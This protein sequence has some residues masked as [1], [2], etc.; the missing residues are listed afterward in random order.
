MTGSTGVTCSVYLD[1]QR[2]ADGSPG[3]N[4]L[5]PTALSGL[6]VVWGR[7]TTVDQPEPNTCT[8][9]VLDDAGG[10]SFLEQLRTGRRIDVY[11]GGTFYPEDPTAPM[12][13]DP[14]FEAAP[15]GSVPPSVRS[16]ARVVVVDTRATS[17]GPFTV[18]GTNEFINPAAVS[19]TNFGSTGG[20]MNTLSLVTDF[21]DPAGEVSTAVRSTTIGT[22]NQRLLDFILG[23]AGYTPNTQYRVRMLIDST[24][25]VSLLVHARANVATTGSS[26]VATINL[27]VGRNV[28]DFVATTASSAPTATA[29]FTLI[30]NV[31]AG[32]EL[33]FA[34]ILF[35]KTPI[36]DAIDWISGD[37]QDKPN[38]QYD[39]LGPANASKST[40]STRE[41]GH[42]AQIVPT[43]PAGSGVVSFAPAPLSNAP[44]AWDALT[45]TNPGTTWRVG[46]SVFGPVGADITV[47]PVRFARPDGGSIVVE[48][49][50]VVTGTGA[51]QA[52]ELEYTPTV[53]GQ[54]VGVAVTVA[55]FPRWVD[56]VGAWSD[57]PAGW[58]WADAGAVYVDDVVVVAPDGGTVRTVEVFSGRITD[59]VASWDDGADAPVVQVT[60][61]DF[62]ADLANIDVGDEPWAVETMQ[63]RFERVLQLT[64]VPLES[65]IDAEL[66]AMLV[67]WQDVDLQSS[68]N[69]L[70]DLAQSVDGVLWS[71]A[72]A[73]TGAYLWVENPSARAGL[74]TL[75]VVDGIV[76]IVPASNVG[77]ALDIS[78]CDVLRD[79]VQWEQSVADVSTRVAVTWL[80]QTLDD[81]GN[82]DPTERT[83]TVID[84]GLE[85]S[86]GKRR[87]A[88]ST[89][90]QSQADALHVANQVLGRTHITDWRASG[91]AI[92]DDDSLS[93]VDAGTVTM[94]LDL[95][96]GTQR[97]AK[98]LRIVD[99][100]AWSPSGDTLPVYLEGGEYTFEDGAWTLNL[101]VSHATAVGQSA[102]WVDLD[103]AWIW[104]QFDPT[105]SWLDMAGVRYP[106]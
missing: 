103:P 48:P 70:R 100:P 56:A 43:D 73:T 21:V 18:V 104:T 96:D 86:Y 4:L 92:D 32:L 78:A 79:P 42:S 90:L 52:I 20:A 66:G 88:V 36:D 31:S 1:G 60:A 10:T 65:V 37:R 61:Q 68:M 89:L 5:D 98:A 12:F 84:S 7:E 44:G 83:V 30:Q 59:L 33:T 58:S 69:L 64:G 80:E 82:P 62:A 47:S 23:T 25:A 28:I 39:W 29:G 19:L 106:D 40:V 105:I 99:L 26:S 91:F 24:A 11:A 94:V 57:Q 67:S 13:G 87:I 9:R 74:F 63:A 54:W 38:T 50:T 45:P 35:A 102:A 95:L 6:K 14:S 76:V 75:T 93:D 85:A 27:A 53:F 8:F 97:I 17:G 46:A 51:W 77:D 34:K 49:G 15:V 2:M 3:D 41:G 81:A 16:R 71:A 55:G 72:H 101:N 22:G